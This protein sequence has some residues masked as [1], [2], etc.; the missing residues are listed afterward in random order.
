MTVFTQN[1]LGIVLA[2]S[3][4]D[5]GRA[6]PA[7]VIVRGAQASFESFV[8]SGLAPILQT[9]ELLP[10]TAVKGLARLARDALLLAGHR[11]A[12]QKAKSAATVPGGP[13]PFLSDSNFYAFKIFEGEAREDT[14]Q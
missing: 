7:L 9:A 6:V 13:R 10:M 12:L 8:K 2:N 3:Q 5:V 1:E 14:E 4:E 11:T